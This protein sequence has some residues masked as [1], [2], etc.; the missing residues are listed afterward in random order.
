MNTTFTKE[1]LLSQVFPTIN[2]SKQIDKN[3]VC[4]ALQGLDDILMTFSYSLTDGTLERISKTDMKTF[5]LTISDLVTAINTNPYNFTFNKISSVFGMEDDSQI[6]FLTNKINLFGAG[7]ICVTSVLHHIL[8]TI[9]EDFYVFPSS[10]HELVI[11]PVSECNGNE[12]ELTHMVYEINH[13]Q[14]D[15]P[16]RLSNHVYRFDYKSKTFS[17][18]P[19]TE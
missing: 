1:T 13:T 9:Q 4:L 11:M 12:S 2:S 18:I 16:D 7:A 6:Y 17:T 5:H 3:T 10:I 14:V 8:N 19:Y 15:V